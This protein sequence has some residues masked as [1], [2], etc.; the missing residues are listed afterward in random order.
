VKEANVDGKGVELLH[1]GHDVAEVMLLLGSAVHI[2]V[3]SEV[4]WDELS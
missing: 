2:P 4:M 3:H 1:I